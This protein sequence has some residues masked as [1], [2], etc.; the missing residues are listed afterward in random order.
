MTD[1]TVTWRENDKFLHIFECSFVSCEVK[2]SYD[3]WRCLG[4]AVAV[5]S[6][7]HQQLTDFNN[8]PTANTWFQNNTSTLCRT[9]RRGREAVTIYHTSTVDF[10]DRQ[11]LA[12]LERYKHRVPTCSGATGLL[13]MSCYY[14]HMNRHRHTHARR[15]CMHRGMCYIRDV[16]KYIYFYWQCAIIRYSLLNIE[17]TSETLSFFKKIFVIFGTMDLLSRYKVRT[18]PIIRSE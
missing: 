11:A 10:Y 5:T 18:T 6:S 16:L 15:I 12:T 1:P 9:R 7:W 4:C 3:C 14:I 2:I 8:R 13:L 17:S